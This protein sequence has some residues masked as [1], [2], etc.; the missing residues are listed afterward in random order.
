VT[1]RPSRSVIS[2][3]SI[4]RTGTSLPG[5]QRRC[6]RS[7]RRWHPSRRCRDLA[8]RVERRQARIAPEVRTLL[9][10]MLHRLKNCSRSSAL[11]LSLCRNMYI[12]NKQVTSG[13]LGVSL[14]KKDALRQRG[15]KRSWHK[16]LRP[17]FMRSA[18]LLPQGW[19]K[20]VR[21]TL[22]TDG[23]PV[24]VGCAEPADERAS[25][26]CSRDGE[27]AQP[28]FS[29]RHGRPCRGEGPCQRQLLELAHCHVQVRAVDDAGSCRG[30]RRPALHG[31]AGG[32]LL[33]CR[34]VSL[35]APRQGWPALRQHRRNGRAHRGGER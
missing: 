17:D 20:D 7:R 5:R 19:Q 23:S 27:P 9:H 29:A 6:G 3:R 24:E 14:E 1:Q 34:R 26:A 2:A 16:R 25:Y 15:E 22:R 31:N 28:R 10:W 18:A 13:I 30:G 21:L 33:P 8:C 4:A 11:R 32:R 35:S 12:H